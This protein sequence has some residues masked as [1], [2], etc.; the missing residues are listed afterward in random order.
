MDRKERYKGRFEEKFG[1]GATELDA[2]E[3]LR[4]GVLA[5]IVKGA[6]RPYFDEDLEEDIRDLE[7]SEQER[8][9]EVREGVIEDIAR[10]NRE[11]LEPLFTKYNRLIS[12]ANKIGSEIEEVIN[13]MERDDSFEPEYPESFSVR[14]E[15]EM[16]SVVDTTISFEE[17]M[18]RYGNG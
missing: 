8:F 14:V 4:P 5:D 10:I 6:L 13:S 2:L 12:K 7:K 11:R 1:E 3:A 16:E 15:Q 9:E 17:Q 18:E